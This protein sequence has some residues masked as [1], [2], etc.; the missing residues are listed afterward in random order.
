MAPQHQFRRQYRIPGRRVSVYSATKR[1]RGCLDSYVNKGTR[2]ASH[3][4]NSL[5]PGMVGTDRAGRVHVRRERC[6][7]QQ[8]I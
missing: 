3:Y 4:V 6:S 2:F 5:N 8:A 7:F 1:G